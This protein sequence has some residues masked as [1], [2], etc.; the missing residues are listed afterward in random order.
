MLAA[1]PDTPHFPALR[2][3]WSG[4]IFLWGAAGLLL[5]VDLTLVAM[6]RYACRGS[7]PMLSSGE[8][9]LASWMK[10]E[11]LLIPIR[12]IL[13]LCSLLYSTTVFLAWQVW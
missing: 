8:R 9:R 3:A 7:Q 12:M 4:Q 10:A 11:L 6:L 2:A 5:A 1:L 13:F